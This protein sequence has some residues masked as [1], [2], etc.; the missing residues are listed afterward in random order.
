MAFLAA[1]NIFGQQQAQQEIP[2]ETTWK[3]AL[4]YIAI[5]AASAGMGAACGACDAHY[6]GPKKDALISGIN[7]I[8]QSKESFKKGFNDL[9]WNA[10]LPFALASGVTTTMWAA[11]FNARYSLA[12]GVCEDSKKIG[13]SAL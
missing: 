12:Q 7:S 1:V 2:T 3:E 8:S 6:F 9:S 11:T 4:G 13:S 10:L 5:V